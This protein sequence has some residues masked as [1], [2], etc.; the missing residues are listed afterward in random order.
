MIKKYQMA[1]F[2]MIPKLAFGRLVREIMSDTGP[3]ISD[4]RIQRSALEAL[5]EA[6]EAFVTSFLSSKC[7]T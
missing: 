2:F 5:Q 6:T 7:I 3:G 4:W 1:Q